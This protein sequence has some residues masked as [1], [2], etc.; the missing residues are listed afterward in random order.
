MHEMSADL[1]RSRDQVARSKCVQAECGIFVLFANIGPYDC[2]GMDDHIRMDI[3]KN[4]L[5]R[6][7]IPDIYC[8]RSPPDG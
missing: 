8:R 3:T 1:L 2:S 7:G 4:L 5:Y 6:I